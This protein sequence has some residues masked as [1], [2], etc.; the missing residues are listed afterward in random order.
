MSEGCSAELVFLKDYVLVELIGRLTVDMVLDISKRMIVS[1]KYIP[2]FPQIW[3]VTR[4]DMSNIDGNM[5]EQ[6]AEKLTE[7]WKDLKYSRVSLVSEN[8]INLS[9]LA[10]LKECYEIGYHMVAVCE[11][12]PEA[13]AWVLTAGS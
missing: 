13:E 12:I 9:S 11:S 1:E 5:I 10:L 7:I 2:G 4:A 6:G 3:D 8:P